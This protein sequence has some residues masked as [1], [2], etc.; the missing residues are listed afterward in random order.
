MWSVLAT[1]KILYLYFISLI[2]IIPR[3]SIEGKVLNNYGIFKLRV[4]EAKFPRY[5]K[6]DIADACNSDIVSRSVS[7]GAFCALNPCREACEN[8]N[9]FREE[10]E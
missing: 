8:R 5:F 6:I 9:F 3:F 1:T 4:E 7:V 10:K 2:E